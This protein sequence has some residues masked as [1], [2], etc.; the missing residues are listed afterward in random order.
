MKEGTGNFVGSVADDVQNEVVSVRDGLS[1]EKRFNGIIINTN[2]FRDM[3]L[4][5]F[6]P[7]PLPFKFFTLHVFPSL[8]C[9]RNSNMLNSELYQNAQSLPHLALL[10]TF[11]QPLRDS[12]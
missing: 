9:Q 4:H 8:S 3:M 6:L 5:I 10:D 1:A 7:S 2:I 12:S 11:V